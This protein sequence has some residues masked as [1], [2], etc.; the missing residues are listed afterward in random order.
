MKMSRKDLVKKLEEE[1]RKWTNKSY[2]EFME[3]E[4]MTTPIRYESGEGK[5]F[6]TVEV[7]A[8]PE[9]GEHLHIYIIVYQP[10]A[11]IR[12]LRFLPNL[13]GK[14]SDWIVHNDGRIEA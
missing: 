13:V 8:Y 1:K 5:D 4:I 3:L 7:G 14:G 11:V 12:F 2:D 6:R 10:W 9:E